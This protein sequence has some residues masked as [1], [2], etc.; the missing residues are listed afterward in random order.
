MHQVRVE[1]RVR[2][3]HHK[4]VDR[5]RAISNRTVILGIKK[6]EA[7]NMEVSLYRAKFR[8]C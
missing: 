6:S 8:I 4:G 2:Q 7:R 3:A 5:A 1:G